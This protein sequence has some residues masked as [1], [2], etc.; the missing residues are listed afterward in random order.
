MKWQTV[1][2][3]L[4][5]LAVGSAG[6]LLGIDSLFASLFQLSGVSEVHSGDQICGSECESFIN[7]TTWYWRICFAGYDE[8]KYEDEVLFKKRTRSRTLHVNL[9]KVDNIISTS[10]QVEVDWLVPARGKGNWRPIKDGDCWERSRVNKI[11]LVGHKEP[12]ETVKWNFNVNEDGDL[13]EIDPLWM[14]LPLGGPNASRSGQ[15]IEDGRVVW[16]VPGELLVN[17]TPADKLIR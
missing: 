6:G 9:D 14:G 11:K 10:P 16:G 12:F 4:L 13:V 5:A 7:V 17:V 1:A 15:I 3:I 8:T 2:A